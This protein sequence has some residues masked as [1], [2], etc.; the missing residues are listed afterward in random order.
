ML[1]RLPTKFHLTPPL[2][3]KSVV[4]ILSSSGRPPG[5]LERSKTVAP[6]G[7]FPAIVLRPIFV[8]AAVFLVLA[9]SSFTST[10]KVRWPD[11]VWLGRLIDTAIL[12]LTWWVLW[13]YY[14]LQISEEQGG[15]I[16]IE[17]FHFWV[18]LT[19]ASMFII[20]S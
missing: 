2:R 9:N 3:G 18:S 11:R 1:Q 17:M 8:G 19:A 10:F 6:I 14:N 13:E 5:S 16:D 7:P 4:K 20:L 12:L 15:F